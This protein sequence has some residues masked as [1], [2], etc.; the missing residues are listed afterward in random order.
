[1]S[2]NRPSRHHGFRNHTA[3]DQDRLKP[4]RKLTFNDDDEG[5]FVNINRNPTIEDIPTPTAS[6]ILQTDASTPQPSETE[7]DSNLLRP[8]QYHLNT[9]P[10]A[11][12]L[13]RES[14]LTSGGMSTPGGDTLTINNN[15]TPN[16]LE[17][18]TD[19]N[20]PEEIMELDMNDDEDQLI[21]HSKEQIEGSSINI[22]DIAKRRSSKSEFSDKPG[23]ETSNNKK[24]SRRSGFA[25]IDENDDE[26]DENI[27]E[28]QNQEYDEYDDDQFE[29][30]RNV[31][32]ANQTKQN[33]TDFNSQF[34]EQ[35]NNNLYTTQVTAY[36]DQSNDLLSTKTVEVEDGEVED[37]YN[38]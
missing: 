5:G 23:I 20:S 2:A 18:Y 8:L 32:Y 36:I 13:L 14:S 34:T 38:L 33:T 15:D 25:D 19:N 31:E 10:K 26:I 27:E 37:D 4:D 35:T 9:T 16:E 11:P 22:N 6:F 1:M 7:T 24:H 3:A 21:H 30:Y 17:L 12:S 29:D 28:Q